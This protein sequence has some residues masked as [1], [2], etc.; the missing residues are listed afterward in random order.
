MFNMLGLLVPLGILAGWL[1]HVYVCV[2]EQ[3]WG[4]LI[5]GV[6]FFP[7]SV[8]HGWGSWLGVW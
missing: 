2:S 4:V 6:V 5:V 1:S 8:I 3:M 7:I